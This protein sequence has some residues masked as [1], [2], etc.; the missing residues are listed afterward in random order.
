MNWYHWANVPDITFVVEDLSRTQKLPKRWQNTFN[1]HLGA[2]YQLKPEL[3]LRLG[4][5]Y[6][7]TPSPADTLTPDRPDAN[8]LKG[9]LGVGYVRGRMN[10]DL[11]YQL[12]L[13]NGQETTAP[14]L[15]RQ[16]PRARV[17]PRVSAVAGTEDHLPC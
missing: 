15:L 17:E 1:Y 11:G 10:V 14:G 12:V 6:D 7:P 8:R 16:R 2:K 5:V 3:A 4:A 9:S 13:V